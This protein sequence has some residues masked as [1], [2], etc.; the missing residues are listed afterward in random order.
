M[1]DF[2]LNMLEGRTSSN[3][4]R[5]MGIVKKIFEVCDYDLAFLSKVKKPFHFKETSLGWFG[6]QDGLDYIKKKHAEFKYKVP[7]KDKIVDSGRKSGKD[8][9]TARPKTL[10]DFLNE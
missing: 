9:T 8:S 2:I 7:E 10:R 1:Q 6:S 5:D 4:Q 3:Y